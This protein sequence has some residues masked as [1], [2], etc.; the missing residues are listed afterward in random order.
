MKKR[1]KPEGL[2]DEAQDSG[3]RLSLL[4]P[5]VGSSRAD[6]VSWVSDSH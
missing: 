3:L 4:L 2:S 1:R 6:Y 5:K